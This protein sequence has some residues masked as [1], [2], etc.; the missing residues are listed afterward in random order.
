MI[1]RNS[2]HLLE[3]ISEI[4]KHI[5]LIEELAHSMGLNLESE[6]ILRVALTHY[7]RNGRRDAP[8]LTNRGKVS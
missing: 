8:S 6:L 3:Q 4:E 7:A 1:I 5:D 2:I